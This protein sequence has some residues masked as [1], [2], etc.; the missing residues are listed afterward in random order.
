MKKTLMIT[1]SL[2]VA[3]AATACN[4]SPKSNKEAEGAVDKT[5]PAALPADEVTPKMD[6]KIHDYIGKGQYVLVDFWASWCSPCRHEIP[7]IVAVHEKYASKGLVVLGVVVNDR[8]ADTK[9][10]MKK[11]GVVYDQVLDPR[12][13]LA[14]EYGVEGIPTIFLFSPEGKQLARGM[15]G[16]EIE[17]EV[18]KYIK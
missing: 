5:I 6:G 10:V 14:K 11:L 7:N 9:A 1:A 13:Y 16:A 4:F 18:S 17:K 2:I 12:G 15:R 3:T 8:I